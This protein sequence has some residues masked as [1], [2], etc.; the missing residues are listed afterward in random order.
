MCAGEAPNKPLQG[1]K[2]PLQCGNTRY[3][4]MPPAD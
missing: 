1:P 4:S 3:V 2:E